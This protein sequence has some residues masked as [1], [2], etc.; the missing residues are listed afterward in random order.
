MPQ[1][2]LETIQRELLDYQGRGLS[3]LEMSHRSV[4]FA[5]IATR[6]EADLRALLRVPADY[7]ILF[8]QGGASSQF[9][10]SVQNLDSK[11]Q[12]AFA[13]TGYWSGKAIA[14][15]EQLTRVRTVTNTISE[16]VVRIPDSREWEE[17]DGSSYLHITDNETID[18]VVF[19]Q[20]P[21]TNLPLVCDMSS[22]I[23]S[24]PVDVSR[25]GLIYAGAQK[26]I[27]PAGITLLIIRNDLLELSAVRSLPAMFSYAAMAEAGSLLNT[28]PTFA[29]YAAGLVFQWLL[30]QGGLESIAERN[31]QQA[32]RIYDVIDNH[33]IYVNRV[34]V[35]NRSLMNIPF[36]LTDNALTQKLLA[37]AV[38]RKLVGLKG[39]KSMGGLRASLYNAVTDDAVDALVDYLTNFARE[40]A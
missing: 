35:D 40:H 14:V 8:M 28:P 16:P 19:N 22:S 13:N 24:Q 21:E 15:A 27:G 9:A 37:G 32:K 29:W 10:L 2:V 6:A 25:Y 36:V 34:H 18:G 39:H 7:S 17:T 26:N 4:E 38:I 3:V 23:L 1:V 33:D 31:R 11:G 20:V 5:D 12:V 30:Q